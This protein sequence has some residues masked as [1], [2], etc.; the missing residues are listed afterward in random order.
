MNFGH[1]SRFRPLAEFAIVE[2]FVCGRRAVA[3]RKFARLKTLNPR[4]RTLG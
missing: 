1:S 2:T 4:R 3:I